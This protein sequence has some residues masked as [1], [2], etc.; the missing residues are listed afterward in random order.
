MKKQL[1]Y[2]LEKIPA[3]RMLVEKLYSHGKISARTKE[4][5]LDV[6]HPHHEWGL[7]IM[8]LLLVVGTALVL[9]G[10]VFFAAYNWDKITP[11]MKFT[12]VEFSVILCVAGALYFSLEKTAGKVLLLS[13]S[14]LIG[15]ML[16]VFGQ[17]YQTG[18]NTYQLFLMWSLFIVGWTVISTLPAQWVLLLVLANISLG[19]FLV[20]NLMIFGFDTFF[21]LPF[22]ALNGSALF[23]REYFLQRGCKWL[24][25]RWLRILLAI[26]TLVYLNDVGVDM[27]LFDWNNPYTALI[28]GSIGLFGHGVMY[29][30]YRRILQDIVVVAGTILSLCVIAEV[31]CYKI[32]KYI[33]KD[34]LVSGDAI[35]YFSLSIA[36]V[37]IFSAGV[38]FLL[39]VARKM[40]A[41]YDKAK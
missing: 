17:V 24:E 38:V 13:A 29:F 16:A 21:S 31:A 20:T 15:V 5:A 22:I 14:V 28:V 25:P 3:D 23:L 27:A 10:I 36:T 32:L 34:L 4:Y 2:A 12:L 6:L 11:I 1:E 37:A 19:F 7:W 8:R 40:E 39:R 33:T 26:L 30:V 35:M 18:A 9:S 41:E